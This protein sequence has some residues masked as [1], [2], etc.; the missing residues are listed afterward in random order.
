MP[1]MMLGTLSTSF[2][3]ARSV[4][5]TSNGYVSKIPT[6]TEPKGDAGTAAGAS[7]IDLLGTSPGASESGEINNRVI[8]L[9]YATGTNGQ[10]FSMRVIGWRNI[11]IDPRTMLWIPVTLVEWQLTVST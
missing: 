11:G 1:S 3:K 6:N 7:V 9:P 8:I 5:Q 2:R 4:N 10:T